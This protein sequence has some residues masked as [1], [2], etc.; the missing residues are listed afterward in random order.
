MVETISGGEAPVL[1][2]AGVDSCAHFRSQNLA[3][4]HTPLVK[5]VDAPDESLHN[6]VHATSSIVMQAGMPDCKLQQTAAQVGSQRCL[7]HHAQRTAGEGPL[8]HQCT[9]NWAFVKMVAY[10][11][12]W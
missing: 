7:R 12:S 3:Q 11:T 8:K 1:G 9:R 5:A 6:R 10:V 4:L 2:T